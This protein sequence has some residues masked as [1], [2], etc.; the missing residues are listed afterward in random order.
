MH[1][2]LY[3]NFRYY[4]TIRTHIRS[5][6]Q[7]HTHARTHTH[8]HILRKTPGYC[9]NYISSLRTTRSLDRTPLVSLLFQ[10]VRFARSPVSLSLPVLSVPAI[11]GL[12]PR[13]VAVR[14]RR[15]IATN[16]VG[17]CDYALLQAVQ[18]VF[19]TE[20]DGRV[21][22]KMIMKRIKMCIEF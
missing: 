13:L 10:P 6:S 7:I 9:A 11:L 12:M 22:N 1:N 3:P 16:E 21:V 15:Y 2:D 19:Y 20:F 17:S 14:R 4:R 8:T 18:G 5:P